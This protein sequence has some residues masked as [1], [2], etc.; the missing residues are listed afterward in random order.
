MLESLTC[1]RDDAAADPVVGSSHIALTGF[2]RP[3]VSDADT[4]ILAIDPTNG[5]LLKAVRYHLDP[6]AF[7]DSDDTGLVDLEAI[8]VQRGG[9]D[10]SVGYSGTGFH[11]DFTVVLDGGQPSSQTGVSRLDSTQLLS[12]ERSYSTVGGWSIRLYLTDPL[13]SATDVA[14]CSFGRANS[15]PVDGT[16]DSVLQKYLLLDLLQEASTLGVE[17]DNY[18]AMALGPLLPDGRQLLLLVNDDNCAN[19]NTTT[20]WAGNV[21][22]TQFLAFAFDA[23]AAVAEVQARQSLHAPPPPPPPP[24]SNQDATHLVLIVAV[25]LFTAV[26]IALGVH[27]VKKLCTQKRLKAEALLQLEDVEHGVED[28]FSEAPSPRGES[29]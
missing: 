15:C 25:L 17:C 11:E 8:P 7:G 1:L 18:E 28:A 14:G 3:M 4:R 9:N 19:I 5:E 29:A 22:G 16:S 6:K 13:S 27:F 10:L 24:E 12:M 26:M 2:E 23:N 20:C 21:I